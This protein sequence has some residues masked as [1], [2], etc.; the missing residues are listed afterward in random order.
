MGESVQAATLPGSTKLDKGAPCF[1]GAT[2]TVGA[3]R[4]WVRSAS[5]VSACERFILPVMARAAVASTT[6]TIPI[7]AS[8]DEKAFCSGAVSCSLPPWGFGLDSLDIKA[9][10]RYFVKLVTSSGQ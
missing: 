8:G 3:A 7:M 10:L 9:L 6:T 5:T 1:G 2:I 4:S